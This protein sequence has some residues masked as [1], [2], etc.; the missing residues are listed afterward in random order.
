MNAHS[1]FTRQW[2]AVAL[3]ANRL[4]AS[5]ARQRLEKM[6]AQI[7]EGIGGTFQTQLK[8]PKKGIAIGS[9]PEQIDHNGT[10]LAASMAM[11]QT[12]RVYFP[13]PEGDLET[14]PVS[15]DK[16][17]DYE[18]DFPRRLVVG[19]EV[20][21][22]YP[23]I[24]AI[25]GNRQD[26]SVIVVSSPYFMLMRDIMRGLIPGKA[27]SLCL[28][29]D[30]A[31]AFSELQTASIKNGDLTVR[32]GRMIITGIGNLRS[33]VFYGDNVIVSPL[34]SEITTRDG[35]S[36]HP[37][38]CRLRRSYEEPVGGNRR[39]FVSWFDEHGNFRFA[40]GSEANSSVYKFLELLMILTE[41]GLVRDAET[42]NPLIRTAS[43]STS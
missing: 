33:A 20:L 7:A 34:Y 38:D 3:R 31:R 15:L 30:V 25:S 29:L 6:A 35:V 26:S 1:I 4:G 5:T 19:K 2:W 27:F 43:I 32:S 18:R 10:P 11:L 16:I 21:F 13:L 28:G 39:P 41:L 22:Q 17:E 12:D 37:K 23:L 42:F 14:G 36:V 40:P 8:N 24:I 9:V